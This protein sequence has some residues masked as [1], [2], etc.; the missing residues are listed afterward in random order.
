MFGTKMPLGNADY[1]DECYAKDPSMVFRKI[2]DEC[3][4]VP[5]R[6]NVAD[7]ESIYV[8]NEVA[9]RIWELIDGQKRLREIRDIIVS[10][11]EVGPQEA[12]TDM[13]EFLKQLQEIGGVQAA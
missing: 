2:A 3:L 6:Q 10:E 5:I 1:L 9:G 4:L 12:E 13:V 11:F 7:L 8:L